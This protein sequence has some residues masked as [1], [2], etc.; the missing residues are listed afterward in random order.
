MNWCHHY[1]LT[2]MKDIL[3]FTP[4]AW[5][6]DRIRWH[7]SFRVHG[8]AEKIFTCGVRDWILEMGQHTSEIQ[9]AIDADQH[10]L[11]WRKIH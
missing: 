5:E 9:N 1:S 4:V 7:L 2:K 3:M 11:A 6:S 8:M 10:D